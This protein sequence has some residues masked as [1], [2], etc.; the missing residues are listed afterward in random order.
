MWPSV[1]NVSA[2]LLMKKKISAEWGF[3][4]S[5]ILYMLTA[6]GAKKRFG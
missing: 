5:N 3:M 1:E 6:H 4:V 2:N